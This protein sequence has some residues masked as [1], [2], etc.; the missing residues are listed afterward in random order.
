[1]RVAGRGR[2]KGE[3]AYEVSL[4]ALGVALAAGVPTI[5]WGGPGEGKTSV[6]TATAAALDLH[7]EVVLASVREPT[8]F[9]GLPVV[10]GGRVSLAP[11]DW[12]Q[13]MV[14]AGE[15]GQRPAVFFDEVSCAAPATQAA[16]LRVC[17]DR[18]V[19]DLPLPRDTVILAA[20]N[21]ASVA[22]DGWELAPPMA[23][24]FCHLDWRLPAD[25]VAT[26][27]LEGWP[28][29]RVPVLPDDMSAARAQARAAVSSY[30]RVRPTDVSV[31]PKDPV[32]AGRA[33]PTPRTWDY[34]AQVLAVCDAGGVSDDVRRVVLAGVIGSAAALQF[35]VYRS[36]LDLPDPEDVL[37]DP[38]SLVLPE[39]GDRAYAV[40]AAVVAA[41]LADCT[42]D[43]WSAGVIAVSSAAKQGQADVGAAAM[44]ALVRNRPSVKGVVVPL[45]AE[46][47]DFV[48]VLERAGLLAA[49]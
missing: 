20:A 22:A 4:G 19:G 27:F 18:V 47:K 1:V 8:D 16:L 49:G 30:L 34:A 3:T 29:P 46:I 21:P 26:G 28:E 10:N 24:R 12:A 17:C 35:L 45:P 41:V 5:L 13:R 11:P 43:R 48:P 6:V 33:F 9:A 38:D 7:L 36:E 32:E 44:A 15:R 23:N 40:L 42:A 39:R 37:A 14:E 31:M 2:K 25:V